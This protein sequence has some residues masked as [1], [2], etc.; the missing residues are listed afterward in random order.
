M[1]ISA[2]NIGTMNLTIIKGVKWRICWYIYTFIL[3]RISLAAMSEWWVEEEGREIVEL[4]WLESWESVE[5][6]MNEGWRWW[7]IIIYGLHRLKKT[8]TSTTFS[9]FF[10]DNLLKLFSGL[11]LHYFTRSTNQVY[12]NFYLSQQVTNLIKYKQFYG[13]ELKFCLTSW[14]STPN[15]HLSL[16]I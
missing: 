4:T 8:T 5:W 6:W 9:F 11:L 7:T 13:M 3:W 2:Y 14:T 12:V 16:S 15:F 1:N 10:Y